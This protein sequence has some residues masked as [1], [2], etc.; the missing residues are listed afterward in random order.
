VIIAQRECIHNRRKQVA[1]PAEEAT[2]KQ[3]S[4]TACG[5]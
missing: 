3:A 4:C 1:K 2:P 5:Q